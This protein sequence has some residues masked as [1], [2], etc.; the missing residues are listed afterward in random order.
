MTERDLPH[1]GH[2]RLKWPDA[3]YGKSRDSVLG[4]GKARRTPPER[5]RVNVEAVEQF[6]LSSQRYQLTDQLAWH[7][8]SVTYRARD[9]QSGTWVSFRRLR[10]GIPLGSSE[11]RR[12]EREF[13]LLSTLRH[14][15][16]LRALDYGWDQEGPFYTAEYVEGRELITAAP[17]HWR[18]ACANLRRLAS[19]L[20]VLHTRGVL[21]GRLSPSR[22][23]VTS[24]AAWKLCELSTALPI[25][26][27]ATVGGAYG[28]PEASS[29]CLDERADVYSLGAL[30]FFVL[31]GEHV[32]VPREDVTAGYVPAVSSIVREVPAALDGLIRSMVH[33]DRDLRPASMAEV[34]ARLGTIAQLEAEPNAI[35]SRIAE[36]YLTTPPIHGQE[37]ALLTLSH[38][39]TAAEH[40]RGMAL[41]VEGDGS[42]R[43]VDELIRRARHGRWV[44]VRLGAADAHLNRES[45]HDSMVRRK[46]AQQ[47][48]EQL[49]ARLSVRDRPPLLIVIDDLR[50]ST[51]AQLEAYL[52]LV[53]GVEGARALIVLRDLGEPVLGE[54]AALGSLRANSSKVDVEPLTREQ[55]S[56]LLRSMFG[57]VPRVELA[58]RWLHESCDANAARVVAMAREMVI[59]GSARHL[60]G[61]WT[62]PTRRPVARTRPRNTRL[63]YPAGLL[64]EAATGL[65][66]LRAAPTSELSN[67]LLANLLP[68]S[69]A[70]GQLLAAKIIFDD[71]NVLRFSSTVLR[72][73]LREEPRQVLRELHLR[74]ADAWLAHAE[75]SWCT[76]EAAW[77]LLE[78]GEAERG[79]L[80]LARVAG[81]DP[82]LHAARSGAPYGDVFVAALRAYP[83]CS[84]SA[85]LAL[86]SGLVQAGVY[87]DHRWY[88][89]YAD[90]AIAAVERNTGLDIAKLLRPTLGATLALLAGSTLAAWRFWLTPRHK[91]LTSFMAANELAVATL[92][93]L[94]AAATCCLDLER[95]QA[96]AR[97]LE[98]LTILRDRDTVRTLLRLTEGLQSLPTDSPTRAFNALQE[99][100]ITLADPERCS[101]L[102]PGQRVNLTALAHCAYGLLSVHRM[103][104]DSAEQSASYLRRTELP[105]FV[106]IATLIHQLMHAQRGDR[107]RAEAA[108]RTLERELPELG[109]RWTRMPFHQ[110]S[111]IL[112]MLSTGDFVQL[113]ELSEALQSQ[114]RELP[115]LVSY[116]RLASKAALFVEE[117]LADTFSD[118]QHALK[119]IAMGALEVPV[120]EQRALIGSARVQATLAGLMNAAGCHREAAETCAK[121][122][123]RMEPGDEEFSALFLELELQHALALSGH[124]EERDAM[125][126]LDR[127]LARVSASGHPLVLG[128][129]Y[130]VRALIALA[131]SRGASFQRELSLA[132]RWYR[133]TMNTSSLARIERLAVRARTARHELAALPAPHP[134]QAR[135]RA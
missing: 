21:H 130:E 111:L 78:A 102:S 13:E 57:D 38:M 103:R 19:A 126:E 42:R 107:Q 47:P 49:T 23:L 68:Q 132:E 45:P 128:R 129:V 20:H 12:F 127:L 64:R 91:R 83:S 53:E 33:A 85:R 52:C 4:W 40:G 26:A 66:L 36:S 27:T 67:S 34:I 135:K 44:L 10:P 17:L 37:R 8:L 63:V 77:H 79:A 125:A 108:R 106:S 104:L 98:P 100:L 32:A 88:R 22:V 121:V 51:W 94:L 7:E 93:S 41:R 70:V 2:I 115:S 124:G 65:A 74:L 56:S 82:L 110:A 99:V 11:M 113:R 76:V 69:D 117:E 131:W 112:P 86:L 105:A 73:A 54:P 81:S 61:T 43:L 101:S 60:D 75:A 80:L 59:D 5:D 84:A 35:A 1:S 133:H 48:P 62:L 96:M 30:A 71:A 24:G 109:C 134:P 119:L 55:T 118:Q 16:V 50:R 89:Q 72:D 116:Q 25:G 18:A 15:A 87:E 122:L 29:A 95:V 14:P 9:L 39:L 120:F 114:A 3:A 46:L 97:V 28:A 123:A 90:E 31:T 6:D 58:A 92:L